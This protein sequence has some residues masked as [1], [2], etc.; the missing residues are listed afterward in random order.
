MSGLSLSQS[1]GAVIQTESSL[2]PLFSPSFSQPQDRCLV[3][4]P[5]RQTCIES[6]YVLHALFCTK[7]S[8]E[9][10]VALCALMVV[11]QLHNDVQHSSSPYLGVCSLHILVSAAS[12][13]VTAGVFW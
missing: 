10:V 5:R 2:L 11:W 12:Q 9:L 13:Q 7:D 1:S 8:N 4:Q 3:L 6:S